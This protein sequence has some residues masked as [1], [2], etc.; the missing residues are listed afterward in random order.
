MNRPNE[1]R[2]SGVADG[3]EWLMTDGSRFAALV[4]AFR[5]R[6]LVRLRFLV[7]LRLRLRESSAALCRRRSVVA[8]RRLGGPAPKRGGAGDQAGA[9]VVGHVGPGPLEE[10]D[11]TVAEANEKEDVNEEPGQPRQETRE[12]DA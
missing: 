3:E 6:L 5:L 12:L 1:R 2:A 4:R 11:E 10:D 7:R 9:A 8:R